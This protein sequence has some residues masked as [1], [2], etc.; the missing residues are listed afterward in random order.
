[1]TSATHRPAR[2][3]AVRNADRIV[4]AARMAYAELGPDTQMGTVAQRAG[5]GE[6]TLY[7]HFPTKADLLRAALDQSINE[8]LSP[9][10]QRCATEKDALH[11]LTQLLDAAIALGAGE[12]YLLEAA[13]KVGALTDEV[14][15]G[16][17]TALHDLTLRAQQAGQLR[18]DLVPDDLPRIVTMLHSVLWTMDPS[19]GGWRRY[20]NL[21]LDAIATS[22]ARR[23][24]AEAP[25]L[26]TMAR[27][28]D[29][30]L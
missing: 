15:S 27:S 24:L 4:R 12:H 23:V 7:R 3:D 13:R 18:A 30:P 19:T 17:Y 2:S 10:L 22:P 8:N 20:L 25:E 9:T 14:S 5:V 26:R 28:D 21:L 16:L 29:W 1:M 6:R 11:G